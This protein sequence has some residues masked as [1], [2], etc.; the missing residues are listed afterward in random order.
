MWWITSRRRCRIATKKLFLI[1]LAGYTTGVAHS[2][3]EPCYFN[4]GEESQFIDG[5]VAAGAYKSPDDAL[6]EGVRL[7][8]MREKLRADIKQGFDQLDAGESF[9][10]DEV[11]GPLEEL[12][13]KLAE[14]K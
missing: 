5:L 13:D 11:F 7:L 3:S 1:A 10:E 14:G 6:R 2:R 9:S 12:A 8:M 4:S